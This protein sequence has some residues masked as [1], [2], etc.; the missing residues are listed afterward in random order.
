MNYTSNLLSSNRRL[1]KWPATRLSNHVNISCVKQMALGWKSMESCPLLNRM[2]IMKIIK[3]LTTRF[4]INITYIRHVQIFFNVYKEILFHFRPLAV[5]T[6]IHVRECCWYGH[7]YVFWS[8][9]KA[10]YMNHL[11]MKSVKCSDFFF[12]FIFPFLRKFLTKV[13]WF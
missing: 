12:F 7:V 8:S 5:I 2:F 6:C 1:S 3:M 13:I 9:I 10:S 11:K 4:Y